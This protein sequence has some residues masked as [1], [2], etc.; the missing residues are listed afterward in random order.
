[1]ITRGVL[2]LIRFYQRALSPLLGRTCRF[3]PSCS[4][5]TATCIERFGAGH[6]SWLGARRI[7]RCHPFD[8]GGF[9][10]PPASRP[11]VTPAAPHAAATPPADTTLFLRS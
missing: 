11:P 4:V 5:Y 8:P 9:D 6:G 2:W 7:A 1:M 3:H 10:P